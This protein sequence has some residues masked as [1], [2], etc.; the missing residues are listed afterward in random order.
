MSTSLANMPNLER[1]DKGGSDL[2]EVYLQG[3][4]NKSI[5]VNQEYIY[6]SC[7]EISVSKRLQRDIVLLRKYIPQWIS[8]IPDVPGADT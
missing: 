5:I 6:D 1:S 8:R 4:W 7:A 2:I 3:K